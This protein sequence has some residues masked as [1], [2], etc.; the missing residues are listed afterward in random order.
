MNNQMQFVCLWCSVPPDFV[1]QINKFFSLI[2][3][4]AIIHKRRGQKL[5]NKTIKY[6]LDSSSVLQKMQMTQIAWGGGGWG[7]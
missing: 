7:S 6:K 5:T 1:V 4:S 3:F 2:L